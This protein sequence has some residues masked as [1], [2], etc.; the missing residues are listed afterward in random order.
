MET[1]AVRNKDILEDIQ[2]H[3]FLHV[4][5]ERIRPGSAEEGIFPEEIL[6]VIERRRE[7]LLKRMEILVEKNK[8]K[9]IEVKERTSAVEEI[10]RTIRVILLEIDKLQVQTGSKCVKECDRMVNQ[11]EVIH[12]KVEGV[13]NSYKIIYVIVGISVVIIS[14]MIGKGK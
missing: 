8:V 4:N 7:E 3:S 14:I 6:E 13:K 12:K 10:K 5:P 2:K 11:L 9:K 1:P